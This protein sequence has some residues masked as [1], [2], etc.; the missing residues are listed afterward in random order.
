MVKW[1]LVGAGDIAQK[2]VIPAL[3]AEPR[4]KL[5]GLVTSKPEKAAAL[6]VPAYPDLESGLAQADAIYIATPVAF[7]KPLA[8]EALRAGKHV[9]CEKPTSLN[10]SEAEQMARLA[11][12]TRVVCG[13]AYYRRLYPAMVETKRLIAQGA[14]GQPVLIEMNCHHWFAAEGGFRSWLLDP[15]L[16]GGGPLFDIAS[17]R[18]DLANFLFGKPVRATGQRSNAVHDWPVEDNATVLIEYANRARAII[19][20]RWHSRVERDQCRIAGTTGALELTPLNSGNLNDRTLPPHA[21]LHYPLIEDFVSAILEGRKPVCP[22]EEAI[23]TDWVTA[24]IR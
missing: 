18:I 19:D 8:L 1:L 11:N 7:H 16:A 14:I 22:I 24:E 10:Y 5:A 21:N 20:V 13:V 23:F 6:G 17:H 12:T 2:R 3:L 9:L 15:A 4:S